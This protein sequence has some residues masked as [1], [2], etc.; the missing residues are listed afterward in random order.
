VT[1][2][3][4]VLIEAMTFR[5]GHHSTSDDST[6]YRSKTNVEIFKNKNNPISRLS[7]YLIKKGW[8]DAQKDSNLWSRT[9]QEV[10]DALNRA[11]E[12]PRP[13]LKDLFTDVYDKLPPNLIEQQA[14]LNAHIMHNPQEYPI[15]QHLKDD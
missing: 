10:L 8:W 2:K 5:V 1:Y 7:L 13:P 12:K 9:K 11:E 15:S 4:P 6:T 3:A 14:E